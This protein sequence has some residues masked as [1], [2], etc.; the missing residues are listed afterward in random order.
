MKTMKP[1]LFATSKKTSSEELE[2]KVSALEHELQRRD[3]V[4]KEL[5][6]RQKYLESVLHNAPDA[7]V[8]LDASHRVIE[9]NPGARKI[10]G[11][12][13]QEARGKDLDDL[14]TRMDV[15]REA[16]SNTATVLSGQDLE[17]VETVRY[18]KD[19]APVHVLASGAPIL[20][21]GTLQGVVAMYVDI[22][23]Q[24][25]AEEVISTVNTSLQT[26]LDSI[27]A[28]IYVC[29]MQTYEVLFMNEHM[30]QSFGKDCLSEICWKAF[31]NGTGPCKHC[32]NSLLLDDHGQP[33]GVQTWEGHNPVNGKWYINYDRAVPWTDGRYV[34]IQVAADITEQKKSERELQATEEKYRTVFENTGT[35]T[36]IIEEDTTLS[37]VNAKFEMNKS[38]AS[39]LDIT[40]R[41][42][43]E[44]KL[45]H[46]SF[47][48]A[49]SGLYNRNFFEEEMK[50]L[51]D[52]RY[53]PVGIMVCDLDGLKFVNDTLGMKA[54]TR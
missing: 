48:D 15:D 32:T 31:R 14:V 11:Y 33:S 27:P 1:Q 22:T 7:I 29:D 35:A 41:I 51:Q 12:S 38:V 19:G 6:T 9:W 13:S 24:K 28:D 5:L 46:Q 26:I 37:L 44:E 45:R 17:P 36:V 50:R 54:G 39:L 53:A 4:E 16:R 2:S 47:H 40:H 18:R 49:L 30:K 34:R 10:F 52:G 42:R 8:T 3:Q 20:N 21:D 25:R 43:V 23:E